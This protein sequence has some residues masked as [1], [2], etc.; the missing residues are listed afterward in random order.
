MKR[1]FLTTASLAIAFGLGAA[2]ASAANIVQPTPGTAVYGELPATPPAGGTPPP[3]PA[4]FH[5]EWVYGY[6]QHAIYKAHWQAIRN[7]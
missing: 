2:G 7:S 3:A 1:L 5:Y 4:G 6:D